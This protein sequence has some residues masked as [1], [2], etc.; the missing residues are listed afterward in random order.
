VCI[1]DEVQT[2][3]GRT[4]D[5]M[6]AFELQGVV[7]DIVTLGK[8][9]GNGHPIGAV[10]T[11]RA[12]ADAFANGMEFFSTFGGNPVSAAAASAVL[13]VMETE[14]L[15]QRAAHTG[16]HLLSRLRELQ[17]R[18]PA[19]GDVRGHGLFLGVDLVTDPALRT[20]DPRLTA[21]VVNRMRDRGVLVTSDGPADNVLKLKPPMAFGIDE[22]DILCDELDRALGAA[23]PSQQTSHTV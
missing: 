8:P 5:A 21:D 18:H 15:Q 11:T 4:G 17:L 6:W 3:F 23:A 13:D 16:S 22:A 9:M 7:P 12:L 19:I 2:G 10:V 1:A 20:P 14:G